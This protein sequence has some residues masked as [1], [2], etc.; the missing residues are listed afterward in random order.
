MIDE[1]PPES[2]GREK[3]RATASAET[4]LPPICAATYLVGNPLLPL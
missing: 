1:A 3:G 4:R 2:P